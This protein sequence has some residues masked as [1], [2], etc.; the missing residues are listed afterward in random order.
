MEILYNVSPSTHKIKQWK[1]S[2]NENKIIVEHGFVGFKQIFHEQICEGKN[3]GKKNETTSEQQAQLEAKSLWEKKVKSGYVTYDKLNNN[4][5]NNKH[6]EKDNEKLPTYFP[7]LAVEFSDKTEKYPCYAQPK[8]DG[9]RCIVFKHNNQIIFQSRNNTIFQSFPHLL[10]ELEKIFTQNPNIIL[11]GELYNHELE[12][13]KI[14]SIVRKKEHPELFKIQYHIYDVIIND[15]SFK[16]RIEIIKTILSET[17]CIN[18]SNFLFLFLVK[19][20]VIHNREQMNHLHNQFVEEG[21]EGI[22]LRNP[23]SNY[24]QK[25]RSK[26]LVKYKLFKDSDYIIVGHHEGTGGIPVFECIT[27][28]GKKF[29]VNMKCSIDEKREMMESVTEYYGKKLIVKYQELSQDNIPRFPVGIGI[30]AD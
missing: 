5:E 23:M 27:D 8:L 29:S 25:I 16:E 7:M 19:T 6:N 22:M 17:N 21:Y 15:I 9:I 24:K 18:S 11:D 3:I 2:V 4:M 30:R 14:T 13:Q 20:F 26:D 1:I 10:L 28:E 12:F